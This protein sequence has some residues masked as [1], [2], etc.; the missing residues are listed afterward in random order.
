MEF[1]SNKDLEG[2]IKAYMEIGKPIPV[3]E[4]LELFYQC[5]AGLYYCHK[6]N[7]IHRD[8]KPPNLF[9]DDKFNVKIG[10]FNVSAVVN[11]Q[12]AIEFTDDEEQIEKLLNN[13]TCVGTRGYQAEEILRGLKF[14]KPVDIYAMGISFYQLLYGQHP[15]DGQTKR[16]CSN[17]IKKFISDMIQTNPNNRPTSN[18]A[19][20]KAKKFFIKTYVKNTSVESVLNCFSNF[21]N[22][23]SYFTNNQ[24]EQSIKKNSK[25]NSKNYIIYSERSNKRNGISLSKGINKE[26]K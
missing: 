9:L 18:E 20:M 14:G 7:I 6:K 26:K 22:F 15:M 24:N 25:T 2:F 4:V 11:K 17:D 21:P 5:A 8:I 23:T 3:D 1:M 13:Y 10:D 12:D 16:Q 19:M